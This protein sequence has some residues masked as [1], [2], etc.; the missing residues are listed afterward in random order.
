[1]NN[2]ININK[3][4]IKTYE[5]LY[6]Y[7]D[8][9][10]FNP[11]KNDN[12]NHLYLLF[13]QNNYNLN[14]EFKKYTKSKKIVDCFKS[15]YGLKSKKKEYLN[16]ILFEN[17]ELLSKIFY[18]EKKNEFNIDK[19]LLKLEEKSFS[20]DY[21]E[22]NIELLDY[23][24]KSINDTEILKC[25][26]T[27]FLFKE[28]FPDIE[29]NK[30]LQ[31]NIIKSLLKVIEPKKKIS[32]INTQALLLLFLLKKEK[33]YINLDKFINKLCNN[34]LSN[35]KWAHGYNSYFIR[36]PESLDTMHTCFVVILL[37]EYSMFIKKRNNE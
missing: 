8:L 34:Q 9:N 29:I 24:G 3:I 23:Y 30:K 16:K 2:K 22:S 35:G 36:N 12:L 11:K 17:D 13:I 5:Y 27:L 37:L 21:I 33:N 25:G 15:L 19:F 32:Y 1:M 31:K 18:I 14:F 7:K 4:I 6:K 26:F 28:Q 20:L 10:K